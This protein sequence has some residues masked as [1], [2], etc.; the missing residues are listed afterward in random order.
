[1]KLV[2]VCNDCWA[3]TSRNSF[4][5]AQRNLFISFIKIGF[6]WAVVYHC[7]IELKFCQVKLWKIFFL[8][9]ETIFIGE[10]FVFMIET[11]GIS[12]KSE[13]EQLIAS[14]ISL[15]S[16]LLLASTRFF[17]R[18]KLL[19]SANSSV[20]WT[21]DQSSSSSCWKKRKNI[22]NIIWIWISSIAF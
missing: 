9:R 16:V 17:S 4:Y 12:M 8:K 5:F 19:I 7:L 6:S 18:K 1:M 21:I 10:I 15:T 3:I 11:A 2:C 14:M 22:D 20:H 13:N